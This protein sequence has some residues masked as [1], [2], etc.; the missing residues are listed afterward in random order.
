MKQIIWITV[1]IVLAFI[2]VFAGVQ[3]FLKPTV[4]LDFVPSFLPYSLAVIYISGSVEII[5][6][7][8]LLLRKK[9]AKIAALGVFLLMVLFLPI[10]IWDVFLETPALGSHN[11]ALIR[12]VLQFILIGLTWKVYKVLSIKDISN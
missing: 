11:A 12:L 7:I 4:F 6:G 2:M 1:K 10:H 9:I 8:C 3:H 5:L